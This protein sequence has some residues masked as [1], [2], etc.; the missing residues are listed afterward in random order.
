[1]S[2]QR[3]HITSFLQDANNCIVIDVRSPSEYNHGHIL[4]AKNIPLFTDEE[5]KIVGTA[6]KQNGR[7]QAIKIGLEFFG[8]RMRRI[9]EEV[10]VLLNNWQLAIS[11]SANYQLPT[12]NSVF[13]YCWRGGMRSA[14]MAWLLDIYGF[15]VVVLESGYKAYRNHVLKTF[16]LPFNLKVVAGF[17]G[18]GKTE[19][20]HE[21]EKRGE[22]IIDLEKLASHKGSA[23]GNINMHEQPTQEIFENLL[24]KE[25]NK[26]TN[27]SIGDGDIWIEDESQRIGLINLPPAFWQ[28][29]R[30]APVYFFNIPF[31]ERLKHIVEEYGN[32]DKRLLAESIVRISKRLGGLETKKALNH[33][34]EGEILACFSILLKYY[35]KHYLKGLHNRD[36]LASLLREIPGI[37]VNPYNAAMLT[38]NSISV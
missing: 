12:V 5:R 31:E 20:L 21:L 11:N 8:P 7:E 13:L 23:F 15:K 25:I 24:A 37:A 2:L 38:T 28:Q 32:C 9:V 6:Y 14:A 34:E 30:R 22:R 4:G 17:T 27:S 18:S 3:L 1:M 10:E 16:S 33:L 35:D 26:C 36:N 29:M 19:I